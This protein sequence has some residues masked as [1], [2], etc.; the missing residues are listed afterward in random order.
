MKNI[1]YNKAWKWLTA[2]AQSQA[3]PPKQTKPVLPPAN[4][5]KKAVAELYGS[6]G[7]V[8]KDWKDVKKNLTQRFKVFGEM[9]LETFR[10]RITSCTPL[11]SKKTSRKPVLANTKGFIQKQVFI[12][13]I[14]YLLINAGWNVLFFDETTFSPTNYKQT[15]IGSK[16]MPPLVENKQFTSVRMLCLFSLNGKLAFEVSRDAPKGEHIAYFLRRALPHFLSGRGARRDTV[17]VLDNAI[18][19]KGAQVKA[20]TKYF[21]VSFLFTIPGSPFLNLI[22][23]LFLDLKKPLKSDFQLSNKDSLQK[24]MSIMKNQVVGKTHNW[25]F[26]RFVQ[27]LLERLQLIDSTAI[28]QFNEKV[29]KTIQRLGP[30]TTLRDILRQEDPNYYKQSDADRVRPAFELTPRILR[31]VKESQPAPSKQAQQDKPPPKKA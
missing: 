3:T 18:V 7:I 15:G 1:S 5:L 4:L 31:R 28:L 10:Q 24:V 13:S 14:I 8:G 25:I 29:F 12:G 6:D 17:I 21:P 20:L 11:C 2:H 9:K 19:H 22:E 26:A 23:D 16:A 27:G 30:E